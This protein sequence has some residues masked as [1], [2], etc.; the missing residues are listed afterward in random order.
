VL[1]LE[2]EPVEAIDDVR[3]PFGPAYRDRGDREEVEAGPR[4]ERGTAGIG[5][6]L[7]AHGR[8][9]RASPGVEAAGVDDH[10]GVRWNREALGWREIEGG[11]L[12]RLDPE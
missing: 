9:V 6:D 1:L 8:R 2:A 12:L 11:Q 4:H 5:P 10:E 3:E 7:G